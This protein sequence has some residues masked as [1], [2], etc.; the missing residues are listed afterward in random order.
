MNRYCNS[1]YANIKSVGPNRAQ[2]IDNP[3]SYCLG[4][5]MDQRFLHGGNADTYGQHSKQCQLYLGER[6]AKNWD[7]ICEI[8]SHDTSRHYPN[9]AGSCVTGAICGGLSGGEILIY[10]AAREKYIV[11]MIGCHRKLEPF[12]PNVPTS[13]MISTWVA[14]SCIGTNKCIPVY[15]VSPV[16]LDRDIVM[17]KILMKPVIAM[18]ILINIYNTMKRKGTLS[19][20]NGTRLGHFYATSH[21]FRAKGGMGR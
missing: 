20:L 2:P 3:L 1:S 13:P 17:N 4:S 14:D 11:K 7:Q 6:C 18:D 19:T 21:V 12:D 5:T 16:G 15:E 10:N 8:A 9:S